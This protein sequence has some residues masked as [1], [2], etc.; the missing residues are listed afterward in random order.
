MIPKM[1]KVLVDCFCVFFFVDSIYLLYQYYAT[2]NGY[3]L[4]CATLSSI[5]AIGM[6]MFYDL[7]RKCLK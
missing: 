6:M 2:Y 5:A 1:F 3:Y 4:S 7:I